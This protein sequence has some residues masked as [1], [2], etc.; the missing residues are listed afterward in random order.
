MYVETIITPSQLKALMKKHG[1]FKKLEDL[2]SEMKIDA[3]IEVVDRAL[4]TRFDWDE[5]TD[6]IINSILGNLPIDCTTEKPLEIVEKLIEKGYLTISEY[7]SR[8]F[9]EFNTDKLLEEIGVINRRARP[10]E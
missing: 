1:G 7:R 5:A 8:D 3:E 9:L 10:N 2:I 6:C 4:D